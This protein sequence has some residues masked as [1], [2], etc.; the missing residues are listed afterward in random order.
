MAGDEVEIFAG[1]LTQVER[2]GNIVYRPT[3]AWSEAVHALLRHLEDSAFPGAP[4][5]RGRAQDGREMLTYLPGRAA[6]RPWPA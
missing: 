4:R 2:R 6:M 5:V 3:G 1:T